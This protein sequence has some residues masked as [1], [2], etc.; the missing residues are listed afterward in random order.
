MQKVTYA[1]EKPRYCTVCG[2][3]LVEFI[4]ED[5]GKKFKV[6]KCPDFDKYYRHRMHSFYEFEVVKEK[7][8]Q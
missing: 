1:I 8:R 5:K 3:Q 6:V 7:E 2:K 4:Y